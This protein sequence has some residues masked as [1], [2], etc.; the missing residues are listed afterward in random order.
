MKP[1]SKK[2]LF[3]FII[4]LLPLMGAGLNDNTNDKKLVYQFSIDKEIMPAMWRITK[5]CIDEAIKL[6]ADYIVIRLN[7]YGGMVDVADSIRTKLLNCPIPILVF[8]DNNAASAGA[9][10]AIAAD[11]IYM[12]QG[13]SIGAATVVNQTGE[14]VPEKYQSYLRAIMR[15]T[16]ETHGKDTTII[17]KD[18]LI[19]WHRDPKIAEAMVDPRT[20]IKGVNDSNKVLTFTTEEAIANNFCEGKAENV[21]EVLKQAG[22]ENYEIKEYKVSA[23]DGI[24]GWLT[25]PALQGILIMVIVAGLY[26]EM[27]S[28][29]IGFPLIAA[30]I[31]ALLYFAPL[32]IEGLANHWEILIFIIGIILIVVEIFVLPGFGVAGIAGIVLVITG[33]TLA[34]IG[35]LDFTPVN[36]PAEPESEL[37]IIPGFSVLFRA[38]TIVVVSVTLSFIVSLFFSSKI[39]MSKTFRLALTAEQKSSE[40]YVG[41]QAELKSLIGKTGKTITVLRPSGTVEIEG[42]PYDAKS[43]SGFI[44]QEQIIKVIKQEAAQ[45]YVVKA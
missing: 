24:M 2:L 21:T 23:M 37:K 7:T 16:A 45:L 10:I 6:D 12:R 11:S 43:E 14:V 42:K 8:I 33:L 39:L 9:L 34:M 27:Q 29:G 25:S 18:T 44:E 28:P 1:I 17:G 31:A 4:M 5:L 20:Y 3:F 32:Y 13:G 19:R 41:S 30:I 38:L 36:N 35:A 40:G 26:F 15:S 22:I